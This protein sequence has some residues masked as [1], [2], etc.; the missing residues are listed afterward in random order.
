MFA[1]TVMLG[2]C[3]TDSIDPVATNTTHISEEVREDFLID[4]EVISF[5]GNGSVTIYEA[6]PPKLTE[7]QI[8]SF[9]ATNGDSVKEWTNL[10][11][12]DRYLGYT[13]DTAL[14]GFFVIR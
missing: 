5:P 14:G 11:N 10:L 4:A 3:A 8:N 9:L 13:A 6:T 1:L 12:F 7:K 2:G